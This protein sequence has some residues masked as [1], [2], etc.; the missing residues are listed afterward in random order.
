MDDDRLIK[1]AASH[2]MACDML[3]KALWLLNSVPRFSDGLYDSYDLAANISSYLNVSRDWQSQA[4]YFVEHNGDC[5]QTVF[6]EPE[7]EKSQL[8]PSIQEAADY[9]LELGIHTFVVKGDKA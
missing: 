5:W 3:K 9:F 2:S 6:P 4:A 7:A 8:H 1:L